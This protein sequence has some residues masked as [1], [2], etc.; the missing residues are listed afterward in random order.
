MSPTSKSNRSSRGRTRHT[1]AT[2]AK[3]DS[4]IGHE[5][6]YTVGAV[7]QRLGIPTPTLRSWNQRYGIG[8]PGHSPGRHRL[9]SETDI[10]ILK[11]MHELIDAG[12]NP[13]SAA[14]SAL[15]LVVPR[16]ADTASLLAS[17]F[18]VD[19]VSASHLIDRHLRHYGVIVTW[20]QLVRPAFAAIE[21]QQLEG[22]GCIDVEHALSWTVARSLQQ[23]PIPP[24]KESIRPIVLAG[25]EN[26]VHTLPLEA[27]RA[28]LGE[29]GRSALMLGAAVPRAA[30][31]D[32]LERHSQSVAVALWAQ[33]KQTADVTMIKAAL[34]HQAK[35]MIAGPGWTSV[36]VPRAAVHLVSLADAVD[37]LMR[38]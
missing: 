34:A 9:Y 36:Q 8:P 19:V 18:D 7:A 15:A 31:I 14:S 21:T 24:L 26:E 27:L 37:R 16:R 25:T 29:R 13:R 23:L 35:V 2:S 5:P 4:E 30:L 12:V 6:C 38:S 32:S 22:V 3:V 17:V 10:E 11:S 20:N 1:T 33:S 28:A